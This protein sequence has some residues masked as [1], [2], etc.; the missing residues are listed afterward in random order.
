M[1]NP[2]QQYKKELQQELEN[3][4]KY[5][6]NYAPDNDY[7]GFY[8]KIDADNNIF[9]D[10]EKGV[11][12][13][14]RILWAFSAAYNHTKKEEYLIFAK[15]AY[16]YI[17]DHFI[18]KRYGGVFW[19]VDHKGE[20]SN[21]RK[22][23]YGLAFC[24][25]AFSEYYK[26]AHE[27]SVADHAI[28][29]FKTI[30]KH[31]Y[32]EKQKGYFEAF[33]HNW[34]PIEDLR[35]SAK[36]ENFAKTMNTNLHVL[37]AYT[38]LYSIWQDSFLGMQI[39]NLLEVFAH[40]FIDSKTHHLILFFDENWVG[41][42]D[43]ISYGHEIEAAWL[44]QYA[45]EIISHNG[46]MIAMKSQALKITEAASEGWEYD[47]GLRYEKEHELYNNEKHWWVQAEAMVGYFNAFQISQQKRYFEQ[48]LKS[49][50]FVKK[51]I[52]D[53]KNGEWFWGVNEDN[54]VMTN[55]D[56]IGFWKCP[57]HNTRA[58]IEII[59]RIKVRAYPVQIVDLK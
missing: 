13:N 17:L 52:R 37:E 56:K 29:L 21:N 1:Q 3:I 15:R 51:Y 34:K 5:W 26:A 19:S 8:G 42:S 14:A 40:H 46:W 24:L 12:L 55:Q 18:D 4:L 30:E 48:S 6:M 27:D 44:L 20:V 31:S 2:I 57:Y 10:A 23:I 45:A 9:K 33:M 28:E 35:L 25:Y 53:K 58:C 50:E 32:D 22:Q 16:H 43:L 49:W 41:R 7:G 39:E 38:N 36:D 54:S 47:G 59:D 11:V